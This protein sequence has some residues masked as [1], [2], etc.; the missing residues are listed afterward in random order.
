M[1]HVLTDEE[2][3]EYQ[4]KLSELENLKRWRGNVEKD[5]V[6]YIDERAIRDGLFVKRNG[7]EFKVSC[8]RIDLKNSGYCD[9]CPL[10]WIFP[11]CPT[12]RTR[13]FSK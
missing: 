13:D 4:N 5:A 12:G 3:Q 9:V 2:F 10:A 8:N 7:Y 1:Y 6:K 11:E